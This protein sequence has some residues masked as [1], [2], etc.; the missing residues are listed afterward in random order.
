MK[1]SAACLQDAWNDCRSGKSVRALQGL[2][3][4][5]ETAEESGRPEFSCERQWLRA[6]ICIQTGQLETA[7]DHA[8]EA[9]NLSTE[10]GVTYQARA[11]ALYAWA[12]SELGLQDE[13]YDAAVRAVEL[14][15][16]GGDQWSLAFALYVEAVTIGLGG[17]P[18]TALEVIERSAELAR[19][20]GDNHL[21]SW[22]LFGQGYQVADLADATEHS[23]SKEEFVQRY[24]QAIDLTLRAQEVA[25]ANG[26]TLTLRKTMVNCVDLYSHL[27]RFTD[28]H[29]QLDNW[30][31]VQGQPTAKEQRQY[32]ANLAETLLHEGRPAEARDYCRQVLI[33]AEQ[34][35]DT[36]QIAQYTRLLAEI[37]EQN[38]D[39]QEALRLQK[40]FYTR[41]KQYEGELIKRRARVA[42]VH[43]EAKKLHKQVEEARAMML[44]TEQAALTDQLTGVANRRALHNA[45]DTMGADNSVNYALVYADIDHFKSINDQY[46]HQTGD[47]VIKTFADILVRACRTSDLV[48]RQGGEE[49]VILLRRA[50]AEHAII[51]CNRIID[52]LHQYDWSDVADNLK[53][54][55]SFGIAMGSE[56]ADWNSTLALAD[57]RLYLAKAGGRDRFVAVGGVT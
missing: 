39:Y 54:T 29:A 23:R 34:A 12:L 8:R 43:Y 7:F 40:S 52:S 13:S 45:L 4:I 47:A 27:G 33:Q 1:F 16:A 41:E 46:S 17:D 3:S 49:F 22:I 2:E 20:V 25:F 24:E 44:L 50:S 10:L 26:D 42:A 9:R 31:A 15:E 19:A 48:A 36:G 28:A 38:G 6:W 57:A 51:V 32:L 14:A 37:E 30:L 5:E 35:S 18:E 53:V 55:A 56:S 11:S 21:L